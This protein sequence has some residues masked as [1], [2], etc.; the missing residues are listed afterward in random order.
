MHGS[1]NVLQQL[2]FKTDFDTLY[3]YN[4]V[5]GHHKIQGIGVGFVPSVLDVSILD[6]V[7]RVSFQTLVNLLAI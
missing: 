2:L 3:E 1:I 4:V 5:I 6:E 7:V